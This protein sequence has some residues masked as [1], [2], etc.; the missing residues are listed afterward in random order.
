MGKHYKVIGLTERLREAIFASG[1]SVL[2]LAEEM[3]ATHTAI[4]DHMKGVGV[5][6]SYLLRY[7]KALNVSADWLLGLKEERE[8]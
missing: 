7:C 4:Y 3:G 2:T 5:S 1:K 8:L 6:V